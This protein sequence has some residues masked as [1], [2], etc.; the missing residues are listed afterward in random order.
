MLLG[1]WHLEA[2][3]QVPEG[4]D[5]LLL[6][7]KEKRSSRVTGWMKTLGPPDR[8][9]ST[10]SAYSFPLS[11]VRVSFYKEKNI[12]KIMLFGEYFTK[13]GV[14]FKT[15]GG[16]LPEGL[17]FF[18]T[19]ETV[20]LALGRPEK[21]FSNYMVY[22][23]RS[24][25]LIFYFKSDHIKARLVRVIIAYKPCL[26]GDCQNGY[27]VFRDREGNR[28]EGEWIKGRRHGEGKITYTSGR[29][30]EGYWDDGIFK[31]KNFFKTHN[32]YD[33]LG[34]H[35]SDERVKALSETYKDGYKKVSLAYDYVKYAFNNGK[36]RLYFDEAGFLYK[37]K[38][39]K[40]GFKDFKHR[41]T[42]K[43]TIMSDKN[44]VHY[45]MGKPY[46]K[47]RRDAGDSWAYRD[48]YY[49][50][51]VNFSAKDYIETVEIKL[52]DLVQF[53]DK[54]DGSCV[55]GDCNNGYGILMTKS[56]KYIGNFKNGRFEGKGIMAYQSG[57]T[58]NGG[59]KNNLRH[60][61]GRFLWS[62]KSEYEGE[63]AYN[64]RHGR[65][66]MYYATKGHYEGA[67]EE[68]KRHGQGTMYYENGEK[69]IGEWKDNLR[70]GQGT[71]YY[72]NGKALSGYWQGGEFVK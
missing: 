33:L 44:Y 39:Y 71:M 34:R 32:L 64:E 5:L 66:T 46:L 19:K 60:G 61:D 45:I 15:Y 26:I 56:G 65:G 3:A 14:R 63:W 42:S 12:D 51:F 36:L 6:I 24:S 35:R 16:N 2:I 11:G 22:K 52:N 13:K 25:S 7:G 1:F 21:Q 18:D 4:D 23:H 9:L 58:Y 40:T 41:L 43:L 53:L 68:D 27:G 47:H 69:Y 50:L 54:P 37:V 8:S 67:W 48:G 29:V 20:I 62:D 38:I 30:Q 55:K 57:G 28:Y 72:A 70:H 59:F 17:N 31:G 10:E 49:D